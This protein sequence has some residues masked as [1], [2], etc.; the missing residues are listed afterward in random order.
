MAFKDSSKPKVEEK[1]RLITNPTRCFKCNGVGH[2]AI[3]CPTKRTLVFS[4]DLNYWIEKSYDDFQEGEGVESNLHAIEDSHQGG[5]NLKVYRAISDKYVGPLPKTITTYP[6]KDS[7]TLVNFK[8]PRSQKALILL[9]STHHS[10]NCFDQLPSLGHRM[11]NGEGKV[12]V[13]HATT[14]TND[15]AHNFVD[16]GKDFVV[17]QGYFFSLRWCC[18]SLRG[19]NHFIIEPYSPNLAANSDFFNILLG[20][21][22]TKVHEPLQAREDSSSSQD[23][24]GKRVR[25]ETTAPSQSFEK[26]KVLKN[27]GDDDDILIDI[28]AL[29][30]DSTCNSN[31]AKGDQHEVASFYKSNL[32]ATINKV[33]CENSP[34][35]STF[36]RESFFFNF[37][38]KWVMNLWQELFQKIK[39]LPLEQVSSLEG[40]AIYV[41]EEISKTNTINISPLKNL[42]TSFFAKASQFDDARS[43]S[44]DKMAKEAHAKLLS[45]ANER[46]SVLKS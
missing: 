16:V 41:L 12:V 28:E 33:P 23:Q 21:S 15:K 25:V 45:S 19:K 31:I 42:L 22:S 10:P 27:I 32:V 13:W 36:E 11:I 35:I 7:S 20:P 43:S 18:L 2:I 9:D 29:S 34:V 37:H 4:E 40:D 6:K 17:K 46:S 14:L 1:G 30:R 3:N 8:S 44:S 24:C 38:K 26:D 5:H 39:K